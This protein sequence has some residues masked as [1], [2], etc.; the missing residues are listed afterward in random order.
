MEL[1]QYVSDVQGFQVEKYCREALKIL[2][3]CAAYKPAFIYGGPTMSVSMLA[4]RLVNAGIETEVYASTAN[5]KEELPVI[6]GERVVV[7]GVPVTYFRRLTGDHS[8]YSPALF[9]QLRREVKNFDIVHIHTW[10]NLVSIFSCLIALK[11]NVP[12]LLSA[13]GT[14]SP[15]SFQNKNIGVKWLIHHLLGKTLLQKCHLHATSKREADALSDLFK[16]KSIAVLPNFVK[17]PKERVFIPREISAVFK[18]LFFSRIEEKKG[19]D[20]LIRALQAVNVPYE[21]TVAGDGD[22]DYVT[23]LKELAGETGL[24]GKIEWIGFQNENKFEL[25]QGHDLFILPSYDENFGNVV[26]ET[27]FVG[28]AVLISEDVGLEDYVNVNNLGWICHT[29]P[30]SVARHINHIAVEHRDD[31]VRIRNAAPGIIT[32]DFNEEHLVKKYSDLYQNL[33]RK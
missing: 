30:A 9:R 24:T 23:S 15:Y 27:L 22:A 8:H 14:L 33:I 25:M 4:E 21:L 26:I 3:V 10:W 19:L 31:L 28:T 7:D 16:P 32:Q 1:C 6:P 18:L 29:N 13:R 2:Q 5:G 17:L 20:L 11:N 12:V